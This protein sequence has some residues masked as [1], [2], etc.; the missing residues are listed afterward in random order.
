MIG[1]QMPERGDFVILR[2]DNSVTRL[3][4]SKFIEVVK[5]A[6]SKIPDGK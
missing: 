4:A 1:P 5:S 2:A 3:P 6:G